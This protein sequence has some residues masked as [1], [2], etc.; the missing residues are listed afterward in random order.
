V[1]TPVVMEVSG[2]TSGLFA[3]VEYAWEVFDGSVVISFA[4]KTKVVST[5]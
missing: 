1:T 3:I 5:E 4:L 2:I